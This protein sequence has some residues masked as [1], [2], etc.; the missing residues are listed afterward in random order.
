MNEAAIVDPT[1][2]AEV[3]LDFVKSRNKQLKYILVTHTHSNFP[4]TH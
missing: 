4:K 1:S 3:Y 2:P